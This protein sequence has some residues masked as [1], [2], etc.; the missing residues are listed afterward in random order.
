MTCL[1][2]LLDAEQ[3]PLSSYKKRILHFY[4][5]VKAYQK[6]L[7]EPRVHCGRI[8]HLT[9]T[10]LGYQ[11]SALHWMMSRERCWEEKDEEL[12][13]LWRELPVTPLMEGAERLKVYYS[14][15]IGK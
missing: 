11:E 15:F 4:Q 14:P 2:C 8:P 1:V 13:I 6:L 5:Q 3:L 7:L 10:L 9:A 12:H